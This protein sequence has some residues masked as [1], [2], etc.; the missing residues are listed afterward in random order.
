DPSLAFR[1]FRCGRGVCKTC[2]M[3]VN[4]RVLRSC[5]ALIRQ[6]QEVFIEPANDRI[7][8]DLVVELD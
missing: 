8:K 4:G 1:D 3:K 7:I 6:E 2:C 5:E